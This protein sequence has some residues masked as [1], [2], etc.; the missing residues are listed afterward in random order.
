LKVIVF[1]AAARACFLASIGS[2]PVEKAQSR[3]ASKLAGFFQIHG[4]ERA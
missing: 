2:M 4:V 3:S 1:A